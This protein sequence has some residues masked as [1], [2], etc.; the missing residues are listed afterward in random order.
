M[1]RADEAGT[2]RRKEGAI[3]MNEEKNRKST[4]E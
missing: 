4:F 2:M 3:D 1:I